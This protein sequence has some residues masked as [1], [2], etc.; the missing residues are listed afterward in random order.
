MKDIL[1]K[2]MQGPLLA[3]YKFNSD[4]TFDVPLWVRPSLRKRNIF[5][6]H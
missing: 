1:K 6:K 5:R 2:L 4:A 3:C